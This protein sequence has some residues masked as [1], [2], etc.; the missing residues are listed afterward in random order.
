MPSTPSTARSL[1]TLLVLGLLM[2]ALSAC[3]PPAGAGNDAATSGSSTGIAISAKVDDH[4]TV[5]AATI[6]VSVTKDGAPLEGAT[7]KVTGDM[8]HAGMVPVL[9]DAAPSGGGTYRTQDFSYTMA[10]DW[11]LTIDVTAPDG[12]KAT[13]TT[14]VSVARP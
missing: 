4:P 11:V 10:G 8:T 13:Q 7:V 12:T 2:A 6:V 1:S 3:K 9:A 14:Q 5:G